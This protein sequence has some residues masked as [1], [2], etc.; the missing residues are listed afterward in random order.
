MFRKL[1]PKT[2][3]FFEY[4]EQHSRLSKQACAELDALAANPDNL[5]NRVGHIK[6]IEH[7]ADDVTRHCI[8]ALHSTFITPIDRSD[9]HRLISRLDDIIDTVDSIAARMLMYRVTTIRPEM[10]LLIKT[11]IE[12]VDGID[13]A[14]KGLPVLRKKGAEIQKYCY[15][16]YDAESRADAILNSA[17]VHLFEDEN[18]P[19]HIIKWKD[20]LERLERATDRCQEVAQIISGIVIEAS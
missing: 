7:Q 2:G 11:L 5:E 6:D 12:A 19:I 4:F 16:V 14:I 1:L 17:L 9:I 8:D 15:D 20:I 18:D 13:H 3:S 10:K